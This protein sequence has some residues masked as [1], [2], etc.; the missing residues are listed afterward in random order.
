[1]KTLLTMLR[2]EM[3]SFTDESPNLRTSSSKV[4]GWNVYFG[5]C[6]RLSWNNFFSLTFFSNSGSPMV[7]CPVNC[8]AEVHFTT[9]FALQNGKMLGVGGASSPYPLSFVMIGGAPTPTASYVHVCHISRAAEQSYNPTS[10][11]R[12]VNLARAPPPPLL[13]FLYRN[14]RT[15]SSSM[16]LFCTTQL[17]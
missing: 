1:M 4:G 11:Y 15:I 7:L 6:Q 14:P 10:G 3:Q 5:V 13:K 17:L 8:L 9:I 16:Q 12:L 2:Q